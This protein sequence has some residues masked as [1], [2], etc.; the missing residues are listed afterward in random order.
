MGKRSDFYDYIR[1]TKLFGPTLST[2]E[3]EGLESILFAGETA[4]WMKSYA[5]YA[6][7]TAFHETAG[8]MQ[9]IKEYGGNAYYTRLYDVTGQNPTRAKAMGN[10]T[11]GDGAKYCGRGYVQLTW[12]TN[13]AKAEKLLGVPLVKNP[14]L[15]MD[16]LIA[17]KILVKGMEEGWFTGKSLKNYLVTEKATLNDFIAC[18]RIIN[19]TDKAE[20]IAREALIFQTALEQ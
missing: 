19:G 18:R 3:V 2:S 16:P 14:D 9:P 17:S 12:K 20:K 15:A 7:A 13:Y 8:T 6:L 4:K 11:P 5:A 1:N 10:T